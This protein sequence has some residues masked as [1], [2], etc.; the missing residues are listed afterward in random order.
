M[1]YILKP[2]MPEDIVVQSNNDFS[3]IP[4]TLYRDYGRLPKACNGFLVFIIE[5]K[6]IVFLDK[7]H[8]VCSR[9]VG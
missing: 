1:L 3:V 4:I 6:N 8:S 2:Y 9:D 5:R 7:A